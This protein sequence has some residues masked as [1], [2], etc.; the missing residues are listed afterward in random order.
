MDTQLEPVRK[1]P[2]TILEPVTV[3]KFPDSPNICWACVSP[4]TFR[5]ERVT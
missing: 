4:R 5:V 3:L 2:V 1:V